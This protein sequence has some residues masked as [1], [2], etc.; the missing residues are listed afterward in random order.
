M[1]RTLKESVGDFHLTKVEAHGIPPTTTHVC[2]IV[3]P[4][5]VEVRE[6]KHNK[7]I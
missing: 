3:V 2:L 4:F 7:F 5:I 1:L 6:R